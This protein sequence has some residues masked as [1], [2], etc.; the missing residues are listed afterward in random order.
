MA[1][2]AGQVDTKK[3]QRRPL[4]FNSL[5]DVRAEIDR[6]ASCEVRSTGNW[7]PAQAID[8]LAAIIEGSLDGIPAQA[9]W[10]VRLLAPTFRNKALHQG[11]QPGIK[12]SGDMLRV[13]PSDDVTIDKAMARI[14]RIFERLDRGEK[15]LQPSPV[16]GRMT[17]EDWCNLH[18]RHAEL[19]LSFHHP[20]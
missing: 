16:F 5:D 6:L 10:F 1:T 7:T 14:N 11:I 12:L 9:P 3:A 20:V 19:H 2:A 8:H 17:H 15:M 18:M 13:M 4:R